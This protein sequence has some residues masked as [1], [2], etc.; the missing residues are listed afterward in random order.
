MKQEGIFVNN[1]WCNCLQNANSLIPTFKLKIKENEN[2]DIK[3]AYLKT[4]NYFR[5]ENASISHEAKSNE[6]DTTLENPTMEIPSFENNQNIS[7][8]SSIQTATSANY[9]NSKLPETT[10]ENTNNSS[11]NSINPDT[12]TLINPDTSPEISPSKINTSITQSTIQTN[13]RIET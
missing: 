6:N 9:K 3:F 8:L 11:I 12:V 4:L 13:Q 2:K 1:N 7:N 10:F 5:E